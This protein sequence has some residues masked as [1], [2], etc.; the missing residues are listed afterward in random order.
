MIIEYDEQ[1]VKHLCEVA[2]NLNCMLVYWFGHFSTS[3]VF[4]KCKSLE[5]IGKLFTVMY[6]QFYD[7]AGN[8][9]QA[10]HHID[11]SNCKS[12][13]EI[14]VKVDLDMKLMSL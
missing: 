2:R 5:K 12:F 7:V 4:I 14:A 1:A 13:A 10:L 6:E 9:A 8:D 3:L 11:I